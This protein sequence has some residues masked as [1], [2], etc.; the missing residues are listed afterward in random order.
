[1]VTHPPIPA[2]ETTPAQPLRTTLEIFSTVNDDIKKMTDAEAEADVEINLFWAFGKFTLRDGESLES[3][4]SRSHAATRSKG[5]E[6]AKAPSPPFEF[7]HEVVS[8]E[9][10]TQRDKEIQKA[11]V[12]ISKT[13]KNIYKPS[14]N[15]LRSSL[16]TRY[17]NVDN[18]PVNSYQR[19]VPQLVRVIDDVM[20]HLSF[21]EIELDGKAGVGDFAGSSIDSY[22][23]SDDESFGVDEL[24]LNLN[25][26]LDL[27]VPQTKTQEKVHVSKVRVDEV[28]HG[29]GEES[30]VHGSGE[31]AVEQGSGEE[32]VEET[33]G[34]EVQYDVNEIDIAYETQFMMSLV[35]MQD[36]PFSN[37]GVT[38][39]VLEDVFEGED[40]DVVNVDGFKSDTNSKVETGSHRRKSSKEAKDRVYL[41]S[42]ESR[43]NL[44]LYKNDKTRIFDQVRVNLDISVNVVQDQLQRDLE[45]QV[46]MSKPFRANAKAEREVK[47]DHTLQVVMLRDYVVELQSTNLN[48]T[49]KNVVETNIDPS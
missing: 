39:L 29:S 9:E 35:K 31:E 42:I 38:S 18:S 37:I 17:R 2:T 7:E 24:N 4:H 30:V 3:Y 47:G 12:L 28:V 43:R 13:S 25:L 40:V 48:T 21:D 23:L 22:G 33:S 36:V 6:I 34:E 16:N 20:M 49:V 15:N 32:V 5:K 19:P 45:L 26:T 1:M 41:H 14:N 44:K 46:S 11:M 10:E 27:N 8:D